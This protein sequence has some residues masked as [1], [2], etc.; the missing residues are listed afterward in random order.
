[1]IM[2]VLN[3][4]KLNTK[5]F[6]ILIVD[7]CQV[8]SLYLS[9]LLSQLGFNSID[10]VNSYQQAVK[11][12]SKKHY[13]LLFIDYHLEQ[14]LNGSEL[15]DL[16][17][18]KGFIQAYTRVITVSGDHTTQTVLGTLSK[19]NGD[20]LCKPISKSILSHKLSAAWDDYQM[21]KTLHSFD[22]DL[23]LSA[24]KE[25]AIKYAKI[26][27]INELDLFL[28]DLFLPNEKEDLLTL[29]LKPE[30]IH[31]RNYIL[32][33]LRLEYELDLAPIT[34]IINST[35]KL[36]LQ[37]PLFVDAFDLLVELQI[38]LRHFEGAL[39]S[40][41][42]ALVLTPSISNRALSVLKLALTCNNKNYFIKA[43]H[44]LANHLPIADHNWCVYIVECF[45]YYD[46]YIQNCQSEY[47]RKQL[48]LEQKNFVR[49]S[50]Y[51]LTAIQKKQLSVLFSLSECKR[52]IKENNIIKAKR[53]MLKAVNPY[54]DD[55]HQLNSIILVELLY[56]LSF[57]GELWLLEKVNAVIKTKHQFN[58]YCLDALQILKCDQELNAS[59]KM[60]SNILTDGNN[61]QNNNVTAEALEQLKH[62]YQ[63]IL[64]QYPYSS[65]LCISLLECYASLSIDNPAIISSMMALVSNM[66]LSEKLMHRREAVFKILHAHEGYIEE[67]G[68]T[69]LKLN[70][71][72]LYIEKDTEL[73]SLSRKPTFMLLP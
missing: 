72:N 56:L 41:N 51:R 50:E 47:D 42:S 24:Q 63:N 20:Y 4:N 1:M 2:T 3:K 13:S 66:P 34:K 70:V 43:S 29:C 32:T 15:Y 44:L 5:Q 58:D 73:L 67:R 40:A 9:K 19:G 39:L 69:D 52:L 60:L 59:L 7:D 61:I 28:F 33:R 35:E 45:A 68:T 49:R 14:I 10:R 26:K 65:E 71:N 17:K 25:E 37:Y 48:I 23:D 11:F 46:E 36:C 16:L 54:V 64:P 62:R 6:N 27:N 57:Y 12:C 18:E 53:M 8:S 55:L 22:R 30:F 38:K 21:F 31:R